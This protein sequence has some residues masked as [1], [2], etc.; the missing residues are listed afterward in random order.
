M[1]I[2]ETIFRAAQGSPAML[3]FVQHMKGAA[4]MSFKRC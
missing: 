3:V 1:R 4:L 2:T